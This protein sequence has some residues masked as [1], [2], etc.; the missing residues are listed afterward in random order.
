MIIVF[1]D[2]IFDN[3]I[4]R[5]MKKMYNFQ[6]YRYLTTNLF[7]NELN[8]RHYVSPCGNNISCLGYFGQLMCCVWNAYFVKKTC[9]CYIRTVYSSAKPQIH[10]PSRWQ[11]PTEWERG[12]SIVI[13]VPYTGFPKPKAKWTLNGKDIREG[14]NVNTLLKDRHAIITLENVGEEFSGKLN[15]TLENEM[16]SDSANIELR[17]ND[18]PPPPINLKVEGVADGSALLSWSMPEGT[19]Y[20]SQYIIERCEMPG[21]NWIRAGT[22]R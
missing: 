22:N 17:I 9:Y 5:M 3:L 20:I 19:G 6:Y 21:D 13:K 2:Q 11:E 16:G 14:K 12:D 18:R 10:L 15:I 4:L 7:V 8:S 1:L